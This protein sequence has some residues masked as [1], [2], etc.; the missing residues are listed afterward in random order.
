MSMTGYV[1][2]AR[3]KPFPIRGGQEAYSTKH[4]HKYDGKR[5]AGRNLVYNDIYRKKE[6]EH[7]QDAVAAQP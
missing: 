7:D 1:R 3:R 4:N 2:R 5:T 6:N